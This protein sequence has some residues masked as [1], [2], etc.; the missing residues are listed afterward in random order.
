MKLR[1]SQIMA[2]AKTTTLAFRIV[3]KLKEA[4]S[5]AADREMV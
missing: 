3:S 1:T 4:L 2:I 5:T